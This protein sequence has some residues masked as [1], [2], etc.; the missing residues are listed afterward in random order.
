MVLCINCMDHDL[1][2]SN[3]TNDNQK[4]GMNYQRITSLFRGFFSSRNLLSRDWRGW[5]QFHKHLS[6]WIFFLVKINLHI[7]DLIKWFRVVSPK[8]YWSKDIFVEEKPL[9]GDVIISDNTYILFGCR[10]LVCIENWSYTSFQNEQLLWNTIYREIINIMIIMMKTI[11]T[12]LNLYTKICWWVGVLFI[13]R[14]YI[15][16][17]FRIICI[18]IVKFFYDVIQ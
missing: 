13:F 9:K 6:F 11:K 2:V 8:V 17:C 3:K 14:I 15:I 7:T 10:L 5:L 12:R 16:K 18:I 4:V 1:L